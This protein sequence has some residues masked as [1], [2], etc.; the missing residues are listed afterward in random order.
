MRAGQSPSLVYFR[1]PGSNPNSVKF[2]IFIFTGLCFLVCKMGPKCPPSQ[3]AVRSN[4]IV[5]IKGAEY[6]LFF[7]RGSLLT[8]CPSPT[9]TP[10]DL[11][12]P[13]TPV[14]AKPRALG[15]CLTTLCEGPLLL[16]AAPGTLRVCFCINSAL[17]HL[18]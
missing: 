9:R 1:D 4:K 2:F 10:R 18:L 16:P 12:L 8:V 5:D 13:T 14:S 7:P 17:G 11:L 3:C 15:V 6:L